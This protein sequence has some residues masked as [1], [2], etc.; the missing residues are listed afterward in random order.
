MTKQNNYIFRLFILLIFI[1]CS[2]LIFTFLGML[3]SM[4]LFG[5]DTFDGILAIMN[6]DEPLNLNL[7][8][9]YQVFNHLGVFIVPAI[10]FVIFFRLN[11]IQFFRFDKKPLFSSALLVFMLL[12]SILPLL[13]YLSLL[14]ERIQ[15]PHFLNGIE[16]RLR[17]S[18]QNALELT[19]RF[20]NVTTPSA[21]VFNL[22][23][24]ALLPAIGEELIFRGIVQQTLVG[25]FK[26]KP[27]WA[28]LITALLF[29]AMHFQFFSFL[30]RL[31]L[32][33]ILGYL[34]FWSGSLWLPVIAHFINNG[35]AVMVYYLSE[36]GQIGI[37]PEKIGEY[38]GRWSAL[39]S[40]IISVGVFASI[41]LVEKRK[42][43]TI[44]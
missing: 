37:N 17:L 4:P 7:L 27:V 5:I 3:I 23:M 44:N 39:I 35:M 29:S 43:E 28:I 41:F 42:R 9:F 30:P 16:S 18:E 1:L 2:M 38:L 34:F 25:W 21:L 6:S 19:E 33:L 32:G 12:V 15:F 20:L 31:L 26:D 22:F 14:N 10:L 13:D 8:R 40:L 36:T 24:I 11:P